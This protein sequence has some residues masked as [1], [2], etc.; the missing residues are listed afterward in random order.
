MSSIRT[1]DFNSLP[2]H[3]RERL[4]ASFQKRGWPQP[5][6]S[7][8]P[9]FGCAAFGWG[10]LALTA[11]SISFTALA[12]GFGRSR[13]DAVMIVVHGLAAGLFI[14]S[15]LM[16]VRGALLRRSLPFPPGRYM[17]P[18]D[19]IIATERMLKII[20]MSSLVNFQ[21]VHQHT[22]GAYTGT[23]LT[24]S[25]EGNHSESIMVQGKQVAEQAMGML[26]QSQEEVR[27]AAQSRNAEALQRLD[28]FF[29]IRMNDAWNSL[30]PRA[31]HEIQAPAAKALPGFLQTK[32]VWLLC[33]VAVPVIGVPVW[34]IW[35]IISDEAMYSNAK[36]RDTVYGYEDYLRTGKRHEDEVRKTLLPKAAFKEAKAKG[37]VTAM[38]EVIKKYAGSIVEPDAKKEVHNLFEKTRKEFHDQASTSDQRLI[39]FMDKLIDHLEKNEAN[40]VEVRFHSPSSASLEAVD[41]LLKKGNEDVIAVAPHF[42]DSD[43]IS[44]ESV[45]VNR[46]G[47]GFA[48]I[49]P[50]DIMTL[51]TGTRIAEKD[52]EEPLLLGLAAKAAPKK[53]GA[54]PVEPAKPKVDMTGVTVPTIDI[55]YR[56]GWAGDIYSESKGTRKFV[57]IVVQFNV[58][59]VVPGEKDVFDFALEVMPPDTFT[60]NYQAY[61]G[62]L[63]AN[64]GGPSEGRVYDVMAARAFD[65]LSSKLQSVFFRPG[66][67]PKTGAGSTKTDDD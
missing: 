12:A 59:M 13:Q 39:P 30:T 44:R 3:V 49:F 18:L 34:G 19:F 57:G 22:N 1:V 41:T 42:S 52:S 21:G 16:I 37:T 45:I 63:G 58:A 29:D 5:I 62:L 28:P 25:F 2:Q 4:V 24:F 67:K 43:C 61:G 53:P 33:L 38:R 47:D 10:F 20:P 23:T 40:K 48:A 60:V 31:P 56:V 55:R 35:N 15:V 14:S 8:T 32:I 17:L 36:T 6:L 9:S 50:A 66:F 7:D 26:R 11:L 65:Q 51:A 64:D 27:N 54:K 46:L